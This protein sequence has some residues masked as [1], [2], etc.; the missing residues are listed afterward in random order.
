M[1][2]RKTRHDLPSNRLKTI[3]KIRTKRIREKSLCEF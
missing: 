3:M 2:W 1:R